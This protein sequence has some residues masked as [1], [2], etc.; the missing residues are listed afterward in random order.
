LLLDSSQNTVRLRCG[1]P[2]H[3]APKQ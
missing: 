1:A 2:A 3:A